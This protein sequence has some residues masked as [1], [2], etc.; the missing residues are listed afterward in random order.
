M[1]AYKKKKMLYNAK[2]LKNSEQVVF[3]LKDMKTPGNA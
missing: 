3:H 1:R 2:I